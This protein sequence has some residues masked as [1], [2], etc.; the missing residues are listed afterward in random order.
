M[1][2]NEK[3][4]IP[5]ASNKGSLDDGTVQTDCNSSCSSSGGSNTTAIAGKRYESRS[6]RLF[7]NAWSEMAGFFCVVLLV[8]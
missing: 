8:V 3:A 1:M 5:V 6:Y 4:M 2:E 7:S